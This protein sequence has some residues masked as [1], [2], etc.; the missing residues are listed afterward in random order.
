M[1]DFYDHIDDYINE[2]MSPEERAAFDLEL[3]INSQLDQAVKN[4]PAAM[5]L[6]ESIIEEET[7]ASISEVIAESSATTATTRSPAK[8]TKLRSI[9]RWVAAACTIGAVAMWGL[10][11]YQHG[12]IEGD[13]L[14]NYVQDISLD[15]T[16][17][18]Q[19]TS[20]M[21]SVIHYYSTNQRAA[22]ITR[23]DQLT[24]TNL[25]EEDLITY[26]RIRMYSLFYSEDYNAAAEQAKKL[27]GMTPQ[28]T[29]LLY[30]SLVLAKRTAE[31]RRVLSM[32]DSVAVARVGHFVE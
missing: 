30:F 7:R 14:A 11:G 16:K 29:E 20:T 6:I 10:N 19:A 3:A 2:R 8:T 5:S 22:A 17:G 31:A 18:G 24:K 26:Q 1:K 4:H 12:Q 15:G 32:M 28:D 9:M 27:K 25:L 13:I 21:D 23:I